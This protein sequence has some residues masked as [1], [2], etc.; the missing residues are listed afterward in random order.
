MI[1]QLG[2]GGRRAA[3]LVTLQYAKVTMK[4]GELAQRAVVA[5][6]KEG[7]GGC[8][9]PSLAEPTGGASRCFVRAPHA[10]ARAG[11][12]RAALHPTKCAEARQKHALHEAN[13]STCFPTS[14]QFW[15]FMRDGLTC[16]KPP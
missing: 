14:A 13:K 6:A 16:M 4:L 8:L 2:P 10:R 9:T 15:R 3:K 12:A 1:L 5:N 7:A 11:Q